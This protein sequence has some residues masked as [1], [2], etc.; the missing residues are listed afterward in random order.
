M[1]PMWDEEP[2]YDE[3]FCAACGRHTE[4]GIVTWVPRMSA[5]DVRLIVHANPADCPPNVTP[6]SSTEDTSTQ[7][8]A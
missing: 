7:E 5:A 2:E 3:G 4:K 1:S 8:E 6:T